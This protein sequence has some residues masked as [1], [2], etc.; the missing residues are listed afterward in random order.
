MLGHLLS[1]SVVSFPYVGK[2]QIEKKS[3]LCYI[4]TPESHPLSVTVH[5]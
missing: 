2:T 3:H 5:S 4:C 1:C